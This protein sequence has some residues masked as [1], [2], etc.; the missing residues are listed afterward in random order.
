MACFLVPA[1]EAV[2]TTVVAQIMKSHGQ[3]CDE[4]P[5]HVPFAR[6]L[7][8]LSGMLWGGSALLAF[9]HIWHGEV[10]PWFPFLTA[11]ANPADTAVMLREMRTVGTAM[12][13][14]VTAVW[15][16]TVAVTWMMEKNL[17]KELRAGVRTVAG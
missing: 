14:L 15:G 10:V 8:W 4:L 5:P 9:E 6:K 1:G 12:A 2:I 3:G 16:C 7:H 13:L 11:A 17:R